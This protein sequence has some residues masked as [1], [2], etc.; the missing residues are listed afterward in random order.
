MIK[1]IN[2]QDV[3]L[4]LILGLLQAGKTTEAIHTLMKIKL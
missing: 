2:K 4:T 3:I 1:K